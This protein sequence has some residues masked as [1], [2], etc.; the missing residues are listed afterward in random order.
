MKQSEG[1]TIRLQHADGTRVKEFDNPSRNDLDGCFATRQVGITPGTMVRIVVIFDEF[2]RPYSADGILITIKT[3]SQLKGLGGGEHKQHWWFD[4]NDPGVIGEHRLSFWTIWKEDSWDSSKEQHPI[5]MPEPD[6]NYTSAV[7][8]FLAEGPPSTGS[9]VV[10]IQRCKL[11]TDATV[12]HRIA[13]DPP[14]MLRC[15][16]D[17]SCEMDSTPEE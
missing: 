13:T 4:A 6:S 10:Q 11:D 2:Y 1:V 14:E 17:R 7:A 8:W 12:Q 5:T 9:L 16:K 15:A 3:G